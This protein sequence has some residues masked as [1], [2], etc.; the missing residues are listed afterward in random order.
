MCDDADVRCFSPESDP[1]DRSKELEARR[2]PWEGQKEQAMGRRM[3]RR[4]GEA[5]RDRGTNERQGEM[6]DKGNQGQRLY[7]VCMEFV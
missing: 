1:L 3:G 6:S 7:G 5:M 2:V 4:I